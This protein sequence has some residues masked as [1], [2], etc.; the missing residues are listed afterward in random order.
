VKNFLQ[1][2][3]QFFFEIFLFFS[4]DKKAK[5]GKS[6]PRKFSS[7]RCRINFNFHDFTFHKL[8]FFHSNVSFFF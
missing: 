5:N 1:T 2:I 7:N 8:N 6:F 4:L 3:H